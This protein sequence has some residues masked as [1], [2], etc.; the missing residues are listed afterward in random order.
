MK[1]V[2]ACGVLFVME[3]ALSLIV[4]YRIVSGDIADPKQN[5]VVTVKESFF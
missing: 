4:N 5:D 2:G 1:C 3:W